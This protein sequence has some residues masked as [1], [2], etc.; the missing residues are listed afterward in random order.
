ME[1]QEILEELK[2][3]MREYMRDEDKPLL[4]TM[5]EKT[6]F[7]TD[8]NMDSI[9]LVDI[10]IKAENKYGI[11]IKNETISKLNT[12]GACLDVIQQRLAE[13]EKTNS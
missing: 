12:V 9:D 5:T 3:M 13:K 7:V 10:V 6:N 11:E 1:R 4:D 8:L 2:S